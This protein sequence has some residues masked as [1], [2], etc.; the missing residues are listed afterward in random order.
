[1]RETIS[2]LLI[3]LMLVV[4]GFYVYSLVNPKA[5]LNKK[6]L[7][8]SSRKKLSAY[9]IGT[10]FVLL[11]MG[12]IIA[13]AQVND[14][15]ASQDVKEVSQS[16]SNIEASEEKIEAESLI[17]SE[18]Y[19]VVKVVDGDTID[20]SIDG[21]TE[22]LRLIGMDTPETVDPRKPVQCFGNE[23]SKKAK[24]MLEGKS[25][26]IEAD[27]TQGERD[28]YDRLLRYV[29]LEDGT[30][31]NKKMIEDG[32]AYEYTYSIPY[33][34]QSEFKKAEEEARNSNRGLWSESTCSGNTEQSANSPSTAIPNPAPTSNQGGN[35]DPNYT[36][37][38]P[39]VSYDLNCSD[40][41]FSVTVIGTDR[42]RFD[43]DGDGFGCESN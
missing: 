2:T 35:C 13:P 10:M 28:S 34:Y 36:P 4:L 8:T 9:Y 38:V 42:H 22:R 15:N 24:E 17:S 33:K 16:T 21:K 27:P 41:S 6:Y 23:A 30:S 14:D 19:K 20:I 5:S 29:Y 3:L 1:M 31:F 11:I 18:L 26:K 12:G 39:N 40:I 25:V 37:C 7:K 43:R 32:Y